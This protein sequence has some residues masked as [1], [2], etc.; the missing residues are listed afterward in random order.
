MMEK[1]PAS[2]AHEKPRK[3]FKDL[4]DIKGPE[5]VNNFLIHKQCGV[6]ALHGGNLKHGHFEMIRQRIGRKIDESRMFAQWRVDSPWKPITKKG[7]G[8]RMGGGK[9]TIN[10]YVTP[11]RAGRIIFELAGYF[12]F[13]E[14]SPFLRNIA[15]LMP[16]AAEAVSQE[17]MENAKIVE[18]QRAQE[19]LNPISFEYCAKN[20][21]L[22]IQKWLSPYDYIWH[23]KYQ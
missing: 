1:V 3:H 21:M 18:E 9:G 15:S 4:K 17:M 13:E 6:Q 14:V 22:G 5:L 10:H 12:D 2:A 19:N 20:N 23:N 7:T 16:F 11:V 8:K